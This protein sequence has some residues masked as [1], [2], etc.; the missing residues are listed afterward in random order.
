MVESDLVPPE[1]Q[2]AVAQFE[3]EAD[4]IIQSFVDDS[5]LKEPPPI[6]Y[7]G[8][9]IAIKRAAP[10]GLYFISLVAPGLTPLGSIIS[11]LC[12]WTVA[13]QAIFPQA[14]EVVPCCLFRRSQWSVPFRK[15][16]R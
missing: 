2:K 11:R 8:Q 7:I 9:P 1:A 15:A 12:R 4:K 16:V 10:L 5:K 14:V 3:I 13:T 6:T